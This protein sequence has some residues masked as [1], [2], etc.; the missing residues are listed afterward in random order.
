VPELVNRFF[1]TMTVQKGVSKLLLEVP[2]AVL[3]IALG[4]ILLTL[5]HPFF[6]AFGLFLLLV[7]YLL[8]RYTGREGLRTSLAASHYKFE[9][10]HWLQ[11]LG[12]SMGTFK[13]AGETT[14]PLDRT[15]DLVEGYV[16][17]RQEHFKVLRTQYLTL[18]LFKAAVTLSLLALGGML[19]MREQM[20]LGQFVA[21]EIVILL[22]LAAVEKVIVSIDNIYDVLTALEK[23][24]AVTDLPL[25]RSK[26]LRVLDIDAPH[27]LEVRTM[28]LCFQ[29]HGSKHRVLDGAELH[30]DPGEKVCLQGPNAAGKSTLLR[31]IGGTLDADEGNVL[32]DGHPLNSLDLDQ[33]RSVVG[34][35]LHGA[36][37]FDGTVMDNIT[38][39]RAWVRDEDVL[40]AC[41]VTGLFEQLA[42]HPE[43]L[44][45]KLEPTGARLSRSLVKRIAQA[46]CIAGRP[47]LVLLEDD[48]HDWDA[49]DRE[50]FLRWMVAKERPWTLLAVSN[51]PWFQQ[52][53][54][55]VLTIT[56]GRISNT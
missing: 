30:L 53:C 18:V 52:Q 28:A 46:R 51:D 6:I 45:T 33:V 14:L 8:F 5:Y 15:D 20:N 27:G 9:V 13:L 10:A 12:R 37:V 40:E 38:M 54:H 36:D 35:S 11:E 39:G 2:L 16:R 21:A 55:R 4:L 42:Q 48:L 7:I 26:G 56:N 49:A 1:E 44:L 31:I 50:R 22:L 43:G 24:G 29:A 3:Q 25:E 19:V 34:D 47:R 23:L 17:A 41:R 32:L